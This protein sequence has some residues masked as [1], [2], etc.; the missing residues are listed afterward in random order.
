MGA[1]A[2][3]LADTV[4]VTSDNPRSENPA[5]IIQQVLSGFTKTPFTEP[6]RARAI[7]QAVQ[8]AQVGDIVLVAGK[9]HENYQEVAGI[10]LPFSDAEV[11]QLALNTGAHNLQAE[12]KV[13]LNAQTAT[14]ETV[15]K[16]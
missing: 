13:E 4:I 9:G 15:V 6:D 2:D 5:H 12:D 1:V 11:V 10:K 14:G 16:I 7:R 3:Q 8:L